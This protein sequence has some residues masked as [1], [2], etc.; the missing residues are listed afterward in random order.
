LLE[1]CS[2][3]QCSEQLSSCVGER[4]RQSLLSSPSVGVGW[5]RAAVRSAGRF[6]LW[7]VPDPSPSPRAPSPVPLPSSLFPL[8]PFPLQEAVLLPLLE[9]A[10]PYPCLNPPAPSSNLVHGRPLSLH[11]HCALPRTWYMDAPAAN[12][13]LASLRAISAAWLKLGWGWGWSWG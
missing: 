3:V 12:D 11:T 10:L 9:P 1:R 5:V 13:S 8:P 7:L 4:A 6:P 2:A